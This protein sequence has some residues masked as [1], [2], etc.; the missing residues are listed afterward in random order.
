MAPLSP[1]SI[2]SRAADL[3]HAGPAAGATEELVSAAGG[4]RVLIEAARDQVA[5]GLHRAVDD[6]DATATLTFLNRT[7]AAMPREDPLDWRVRWSQR[8]RRP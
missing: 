2:A 1:H 5:A 3:A 6:F 7:L 8:F 4:D